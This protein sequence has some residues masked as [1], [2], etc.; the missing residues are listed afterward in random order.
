MMPHH[1][2]GSSVVNNL[3]TCHKTQ[4]EN[5]AENFYSAEGW[6]IHTYT[7]TPKGFSYGVHKNSLPSNA[8]QHVRGECKFLVFLVK[9]GEYEE[10][11]Y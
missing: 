5:W 3:E 1:G 7:K 11:I 6:C 2:T 4:Q 9:Q 8:N 10:E